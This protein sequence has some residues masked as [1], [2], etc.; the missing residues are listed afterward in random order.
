MGVMVSRMG[1]RRCY[2][3]QNVPVEEMLVFV[4]FANKVVCL[5]THKGPDEWDLC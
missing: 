4:V 3:T 1:T 2:P 5:C